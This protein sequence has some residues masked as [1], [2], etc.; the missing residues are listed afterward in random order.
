MDTLSE[1]KGRMGL[2]VL[3]LALALFAAATPAQAGCLRMQIRAE[4]MKI[5]FLNRPVEEKARQ[6]AILAWENM[7]AKK[8]G[9]AYAQWRNA[10][11]RKMQCRLVSRS[12]TLCTAAATPCDGK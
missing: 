6:S 11:G 12:E 4:G 9:A 7:A 1:D 5:H 2:P 8:A 3:L 10:K